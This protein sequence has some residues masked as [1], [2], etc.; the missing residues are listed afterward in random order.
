MKLYL[1]DIVQIGG[2]LA[3]TIGSHPEGLMDCG[4]CSSPNHVFDLQLLS[5]KE[6][7]RGIPYNVLTL[8]DHPEN[9]EQSIKIAGWSSVD[10]YHDFL[11][12]GAKFNDPNPRNY[13][14]VWFKSDCAT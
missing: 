5:T 13:N 2:E 3:K 4:C 12:K 6:I 1:G 11:F 14:R 10:E 8:I 9:W 7:L